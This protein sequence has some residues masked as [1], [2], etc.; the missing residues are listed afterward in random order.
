MPTPVDRAESVASVAREIVYTI[1]HSNNA[2]ADFIDLLKGAGVG[3]IA[4]VRSTPFSRRNP[5]F[6]RETLASSLKDNAVAYVWLGDQLGARPS[7]PSLLR[8][9]GGV[10]FRRLVASAAF[11]RGIE[12]VC[13]GARRFRLAIMCAERDPLNCHRTFLIARHLAG[14]HV[15]IRHVLGDGQ[16]IEHQDVER[17]VIANAFPNGRDFFVENEGALLNE[18]YDAWGRKP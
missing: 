6:N 12:R 11:R 7:D 18:A 1:G 17:R 8:A 9:D 14:E 16:I 4:D 15:G 13:D 10:D 5:Q 3:A 2:S